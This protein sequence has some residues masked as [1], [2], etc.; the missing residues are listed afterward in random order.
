MPP[1]GC[2]LTDLSPFCFEVRQNFGLCYGLLF[3]Y[4]TFTLFSTHNEVL[5]GYAVVRYFAKSS[6]FEVWLCSL[7]LSCY[8][9]NSLIVCSWVCLTRPDYLSVHLKFFANKNEFTSQQPILQ[10]MYF[11]Y[12]HFIQWEIEV[13]KDSYQVSPINWT[14]QNNMTFF[15]RDCLKYRWYIA[16]ACFCKSSAFLQIS[17]RFSRQR[18]QNKDHENEWLLFEKFI[19]ND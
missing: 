9:L 19:L 14:T 11:Y 6:Q 13:W 8:F 17:L 10:M 15:F 16:F 2:L 12:F 3:P 4:K 18:P 5:P 1:A 7:F